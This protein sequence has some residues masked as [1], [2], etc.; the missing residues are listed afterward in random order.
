MSHIIDTAKELLCDLELFRLPVNPFQVSEKLEITLVEKDLDSFDGCIQSY[1]DNCLIMINS[2]ISSPERKNFTCAHELGHYSY[3]LKAL[4]GKELMCTQDNINFL[5]KRNTTTWNSRELRANLF[6]SEI[7][8]PTDLIKPF[9]IN[10]EPSWELF[11]ELKD[12]CKVSMPAILTKFISL[13]NQICWFVEVKDGI[14]NR[15]LKSNEAANHLNI[16]TKIR[17]KL[18]PTI[19]WEECSPFS[20]FFDDSLPKNAKRKKILYTT[21]ELKKFNIQ[22]VILWDNEGVLDEEYNEEDYD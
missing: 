19:V 18:K 22:Y 7:L 1:Q 12:V 11:H 20:W 13:T 15:F 9:I 3:D 4:N 2:K 21:F 16:V 17:N 10:K 8:M 6:A 14:V 5:N